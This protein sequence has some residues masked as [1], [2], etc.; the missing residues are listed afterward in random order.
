MKSD[1]VNR[2]YTLMEAVIEFGPVINVTTPNPLASLQKVRL[3]TMPPPQ[4]L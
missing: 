4:T 3:P 2:L 1:G